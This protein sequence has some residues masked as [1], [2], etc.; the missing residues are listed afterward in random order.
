MWLQAYHADIRRD[1]RIKILQRF[2]DRELDVLVPGT[3]Q[4]SLRHLQLIADSFAVPRAVLEPLAGYPQPIVSD[5]DAELEATVGR[6]R[7]LLEHE[8]PR[9][10]WPAYVRACEAVAAGIGSSVV[11]AAA[12]QSSRRNLGFTR[13]PAPGDEG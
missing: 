9:G 10:L 1:D 7:Q 6:L 12:A 3:V 8:V 2:K 5:Q 13:Q 4:P 11:E